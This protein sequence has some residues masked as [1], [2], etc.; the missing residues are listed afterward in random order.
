MFV[1]VSATVTNSLT[2]IAL[3]NDKTATTENKASMCLLGTF[4]RGKHSSVNSVIT[5]LP[6][7]WEGKLV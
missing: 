6:F 4:E 1:Y 5:C 3:F 7:G 2:F